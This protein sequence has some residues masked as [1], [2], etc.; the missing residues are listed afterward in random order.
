MLPTLCALVGME[1]PNRPLDG[2]NL[3]PLID[4]QMDGRPE[5]ICF[6]S[7][8]GQVAAKAKPW[9]EPALQEG[10][11]PLVKLMAGKPTRTFRNFH[12]EQIRDGDFAGPRT[13]IG[14]RY[15]LVVTGKGE[16][17]KTELFDL[18]SDP[19]ESKDLSEQEAPIAKRMSAQLYQWQQSVLQSLTGADYR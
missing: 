18:R 17:Q 7:Y 5:P 16:K 9:I 13:I 2:I 15:K 19:A 4:G 1:V 8:G 3:K 14:N 11:T 6:W 10:T 12:H